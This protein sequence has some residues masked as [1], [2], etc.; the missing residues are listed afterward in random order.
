MKNLIRAPLFLFAIIAIFFVSFFINNSVTFAADKI[1]INTAN[2]TELD[3]IPEVGPSTALK[4]IAYRTANGLFLVIED[5]MKVSGI[6][7]ASFDK[8]KDYITVS[9]DIINNDNHEEATTTATTTDPIITTTTE[10]SSSTVS[11]TTATSTSPAVLVIYSVHYIEEDLSNFVEPTSLEINAGRVRLSYVNSVLSFIVKYKISKD[12]S[13]KDCEYLWNFG[14]GISMEGEKV[15]HIYKY[16]GDYNVVLN[17]N[18]GGL[19]AVSRTTVKVLTPNLILHVLDDGSVEIKN[20]GSN[21]INLYGWKI[22]ASNSSYN[23]PMDTIISAG[24]SVTFPLEYLKLATIGNV[25]TINDN[26]SK[27]IAQT[28][29]LSLVENSNN[30]KV[31]SKVDLDK[32]ILAYMKTPITENPVVIVS[33][34]TIKDTYNTIPLMASVANVFITSTSTDA[35]TVNSEISVPGFWSK[36]FHPIRTIRGTFYR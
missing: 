33:P 3:A 34:V 10:F 26:L 29:I 32:F 9:S 30:E 23:F 7:Q 27:I 35:G 16:A 19:Q 6:K 12:I 20:N 11:T 2:A 8:M 18:C 25:V 14:D 13:N 15:E 28:D 22:S 31:I 36:L 17:G 4:I 1:N 5:I 24:N 21:E